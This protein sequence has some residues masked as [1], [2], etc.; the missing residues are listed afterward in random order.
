MNLS[1][2]NKIPREGTFLRRLH[3][4]VVSAVSSGRSVVIHLPNEPCNYIHGSMHVLRKKYG[5][6]CVFSTVGDTLII[7]LGGERECKS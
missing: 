7:G 2:K 4:R 6:N 3:D 5:V 1:I